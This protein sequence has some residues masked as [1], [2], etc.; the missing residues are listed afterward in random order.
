MSRYF[1]LPQIPGPEELFLAVISLH[2]SQFAL[3]SICC[4]GHSCGKLPLYGANAPARQSP[5]S[6]MTGEYSE[7]HTR[8]RAI[9][10]LE[11]CCTSI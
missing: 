5:H 1:R 2:N 3:L 9:S 4:V 6:A 7:T 11:E 10:S 8:L